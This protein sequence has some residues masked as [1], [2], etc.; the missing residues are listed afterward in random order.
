M[1]KLAIYTKEGLLGYANGI[2]PFNIPGSTA[3]M[4]DGFVPSSLLEIPTPIISPIAVEPP[5]EYTPRREV[6]NERDVVRDRLPN[7][8]KRRDTLLVMEDGKEVRKKVGQK[9]GELFHA[10]YMRCPNCGQSA[11][12]SVDGGVVIRELDGDQEILKTGTGID[13]QNYRYEDYKDKELTIVELAADEFLQGFCP[14]CLESNAVLKWIHA[15]EDPLAYFEFEF[16]CCLCGSETVTLF[17]EDECKIIR[18]CEN[19]KCNYEQF[20]KGDKNDE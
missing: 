1:S 9:P 8:D 20:I 19:K 14:C 6:T 5:L 15:W 17:R 10:P 2:L 4:L 13:M 7:L 11:I 12:I 16:P 3:L 18:K